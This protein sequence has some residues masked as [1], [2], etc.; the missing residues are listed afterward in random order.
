MKTDVDKLRTFIDQISPIAESYGKKSVIANIKA[1]LNELESS[2]SVLFCGEFKR[3]KSSLVNA[4]IRDALCP[5]DV[6]I[7]TSVVSII[8][9]GTVKKAY[10]YYGNLL[11]KAESLKKEEIEWQ[12]IKK[13]TMGDVLDIDNTILVELFCPATFLKDGIN[14][15]DTPG[16]GGLDPRHAILTQMVLP[17]ADIIVFVTDA[18]EPMTDSELKFYQDK[19]L[20]CRKQNLVLINKSDCLTE[21][22]LKTHIDTTKLTLSKVDTPD[23]LPVSAEHWS[24]YN[25]FEDED[26]LNCSNKNRVL[27]SIFRLVEN[28]RKKQLIELKNIL[29]EDISEILNTVKTELE[30][31]NTN[32]TLHQETMESLKQQLEELRKFIND[33]KNPQSTINLSISSIFEDARNQVSNTISH[34]GTILTSTDFDELLNCENGLANDG[35]WFVSQINDKLQALSC[36]VDNEIE[37]AFEKISKEVE[38]EIS[39]VFI[40]DTYQVSD[41]LKS[42]KILNSQLAFSLAS[43]LTTGSLIGT[44]VYIALSQ[45]LIPGIGI[46]AGFSTAAALIWRQLTRE[47]QQQKRASIRQQVLPKVNLAITDLRNQANTRF[48]KFHQN[49]LQTLQTIASEAE[50]KIKVIQNSMKESFGNEQECKNKISALQQRDKFLQTIASQLSLLYTSPFKNG[51]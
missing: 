31:L 28:F 39:D 30:Q 45:L 8:R 29:L 3:G 23:V 2:T 9:Y 14:I 33:I 17:K 27:A 10:R 41:N 42:H 46:I 18:V 19:I 6:G 32:S 24:N 20:P 1:K 40:T 43:K 51:K 13:Y 21:D 12:D 44:G 25:L 11:E 22:A 38:M 35:K 50:E 49:L 34:E 37:E 15:I 16:I 7:A 48:S 26:L 36:K 4:I 47:N 5:T